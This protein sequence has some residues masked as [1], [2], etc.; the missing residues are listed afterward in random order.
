MLG[1]SNWV[2][3]DGVLAMAMLSVSLYLR[4]A[5]G[6]SLGNSAMVYKASM[7]FNYC[8]GIQMCYLLCVLTTRL[9]LHLNPL[10]LTKRAVAV[11]S[12]RVFS[13]CLVALVIVGVV[14]MF[15]P[16]VQFAGTGI[17]LV[18]AALV[19]IVVIC[20]SLA[21]VVAFT[22]KCPGASYSKRHYAILY[23]A[24]FLVTLWATF[25]GARTLVPLDNAAHSNEIMQYLLIYVPLTLTGTI[26]VVL[27][28]PRYFNFDLASQW[29]AQL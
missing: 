29:Q 22:M 21:I 8:A 13:V 27:K 16:N 14:V 26:F 6:M 12:A 24:L 20:I 28:A 11:A 9:H 25:A 3:A 23:A 5:L 1:Y 15:D 7:A 18:Q 19:A 10:I 4:A 17:R 2:F